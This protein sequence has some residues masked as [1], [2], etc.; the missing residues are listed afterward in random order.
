M[1]VCVCMCVL[2]SVSVRVCVY[3]FMS[4]TSVSV[5]VCV[6][7]CVSVCSWLFHQKKWE[8]YPPVSGS[9]LS[10]LLVFGKE[11]SGSCLPQLYNLFV[12]LR[13]NE[14]TSLSCLPLF[15]LLPPLCVPLSSPLLSFPLLSFP[16]LSLLSSP[17]FPLLSS[18]PPSPSSPFLSSPLLPSPLLLL[19]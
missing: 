19:L 4:S 12:Q 15:H 5:C 16:L 14:L 2:V 18:P 17:P 7:V 10:V 1:Y 11:E 6:C 9:Q 8:L 3:P 13:E